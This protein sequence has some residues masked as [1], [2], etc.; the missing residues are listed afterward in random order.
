MNAS[1]T[2]ATG[3][4]NPAKYSWDVDNDGDGVADSVWIDVGLAV[5]TAVDG[6]TY[7][8]LVAYM[9]LDLDGRLNVNAHGNPTQTEADYAT[10]QPST[11]PTTAG[12]FAP[13]SSGGATWKKTLQPDTGTTTTPIG[14][15]LGSG[16]GPADINL[17]RKPIRRPCRQDLPQIR[18]FL[19]S[20]NTRD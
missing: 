7:K 13:N 11:P 1:S 6:T 19:T 20:T 5:Q 2:D 8:P 16:F 17:G 15:T 12:Y 18:Y 4:V 3:A 10:A 14:I 9:C